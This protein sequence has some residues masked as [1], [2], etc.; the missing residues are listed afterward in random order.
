MG[1]AE[2][3]PFK[4]DGTLL[5]PDVLER[6]TKAVSVA[7]R[8]DD[9]AVESI[10]QAPTPLYAQHYR[11]VNAT[12]DRLTARLVTWI[13]ERRFSACAVPASQI[14]DE[15]NLLG[16]IS[17]KAVAR[18]AGIGWQGKSLLIIS[19]QYG[20]RIRLAT[21]L[22]DM[23]LSPNQPLKN[24]CG[25]CK[26][27]SKACPA[28]AIK[29]TRTADRYASREEALHFSRCVEQTRNFKARLGIEAQIC[30]ICVRACPFGRRTCRNS[31]S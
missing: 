1:V 6:F 30:G 20:P 7:V 9:A 13:S 4:A 25:T 31:P 26:E 27:C 3:A 8:L 18:L 24:R 23:P 29:N 12:L 21:L 22:T 2:L 17:H 19:P 5:P 28:S 10:E 11:A 14:V 16:S 15:T